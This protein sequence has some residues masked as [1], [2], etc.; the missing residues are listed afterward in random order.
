MTTFLKTTATALLVVFLG[1]G[2][3]TNSVDPIALEEATAHGLVV[4]QD[5]QGRFDLEVPE[6]WLF[7][8]AATEVQWFATLD[9]G[10]VTMK[11]SLFDETRP[12]VE[13][14]T[15]SEEDR[16]T[17]TVERFEEST[18]NGLPVLVREARNIFG[19][20]RAYYYS[21]EDSVVALVALY[22]ESVSTAEHDR[23]QAVFNSVRATNP[24]SH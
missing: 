17:Q 18:V 16:A 5:P 3:A 21:F 10:E 14:Q 15:F 12:L 24:S 4:Y 6:A 1:S 13:V 9:S 2:C 23:V 20:S 8:Q 11:L 19:S 7:S 22:G